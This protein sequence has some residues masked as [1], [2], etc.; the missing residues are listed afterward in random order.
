MPDVLSKCHQHHKQGLTGS[1]TRLHICPLRPNIPLLLTNRIDT[2][3]KAL[4]KCSAPGK[5]DKHVGTRKG[6]IHLRK[7][8]VTQEFIREFGNNRF[9]QKINGTEL[10]GP[11][12]LPVTV[13]RCLFGTIEDLARRSLSISHR[14]NSSRSF[15]VFPEPF[16]SN[17]IGLIGQE[18]EMVADLSTI[19]TP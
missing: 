10:M 4:G 3:R 5:I 1:R 17:M 6:D 18:I 14:P 11:L 7:G 2:P 13:Q 9:S 15:T 8:T 16:S 12:H 19:G